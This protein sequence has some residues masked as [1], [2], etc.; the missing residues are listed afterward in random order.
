MRAKLR[1]EGKWQERGRDPEPS[2]ST[3]R[4]RSPVR[5][6]AD[7]SIPG[8]LFPICLTPSM[9][10]NGDSGEE[11]SVSMQF[12]TE[13]SAKGSQKRKDPSPVRDISESEDECEGTSS[14]KAR[15]INCTVLH[16]ARDTQKA[17]REIEQLIRNRENCAGHYRGRVDG[18]FGSP[19]DL[20][21][22]VMFSA[23][24]SPLKFTVLDKFTINDD[25][26]LPMLSES[27]FDECVSY[28]QTYNSLAIVIRTL[29]N[30]TIF[31]IDLINY[32]DD[33]KDPYILICEKSKLNVWHWHMI[34]FTDKRSDNAKRTLMGLFHL[35]KP[36]KEIK[37]PKLSVS[38]QQTKSFKHLLKYILKD[39]IVLC[40]RNDLNLWKLCCTQLRITESDEIPIQT[41]TFPNVMVKEIIEIMRKHLK[42]TSEELMQCA[43]EIMRKYLHKSNIDSIIHNCK[44]YLLAPTDIEAVYNRICSKKP[45]VLS[46]F[47]IYSYIKYQELTP[48][49]FILKLFKVLFMDLDKINC[50]CLQGPSN[51]G[52]TSFLHGLVKHYNYGEIQ[53]SGQF[54]FQNCIN[55]EL[56]L[57][58]EPLIGHDFVENVK[59][60]FEGMATQVSVKYKPAQTLYRTP[61]LI[62]TNK[63]LWHYTDVDESAIRNRIYLYIFR[64]PAADYP[65]WLRRNFNK[66]RRSYK[67]FV[68]G[69]SFA[70]TELLQRHWSGIESDES[71]C[72]SDCSVDSEPG[73]ADWESTSTDNLQRSTYRKQLY[74]TTCHELLSWWNN[75]RRGGRSKRES[76]ECTER[77]RSSSCDSSS[78]D[79]VWVGPSNP[80]GDT[81]SERGF[82]YVKRTSGGTGFEYL[83]SGSNSANGHRR[84]RANK[85]G[86]TR[87]SN[88][89]VLRG[90]K[91]CPKYLTQFYNSNFGSGILKKVQE[92]KACATKSEL[93]WAFDTCDRIDEY[94]WLSLIKLFWEFKNADC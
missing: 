59:K 31:T 61:V 94:Q 35:E 51:T 87:S 17:A 46:F 77:Q 26:Y 85:R 78:T 89:G 27:E 12:D 36:G 50:F 81:I 33:I 28:Y 32:M 57:W 19:I 53:S 34:W 38:V 1:R 30:T 54:M 84:F 75:N 91:S 39:P 90:D 41:E 68:A 23:P 56:L 29:P 25:E 13:L 67:Q 52:K 49:L 10:D 48:E 40:V 66:C 3:H 45:D 44:M 70:I 71:A 82:T 62:T 73:F 9:F 2:T 21:S 14:K 43:P 63:D 60:V 79:D 37:S 64:R 65:E 18:I 15:L 55:K 24:E 6:E 86:N 4:E 20:A 47:H 58:E 5:T 76:L 69:V 80:T 42:Y 22:R 16:E 88:R 92:S 93:G 83:P 8:K 7:S 11:I 74:H 72:S